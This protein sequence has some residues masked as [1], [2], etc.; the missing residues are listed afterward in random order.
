MG[1]T[2][3]LTKS[4]ARFEAPL[5]LTR[6]DFG[7]NN[8]G[9]N[10]PSWEISFAINFNPD[11]N[12][13]IGGA[14]QDAELWEIGIVQNLLFERMLYEYTDTPAF[15]AEFKRSRVDIVDNS[16]DRPFYSSPDVGSGRRKIRPVAHIWY[17]SQ[18]Y[19]EVLDPSNSSGVQTNN[20]PDSLN[21]WDQPS[22]GVLLRRDGSLLKRIEKVLSFQAWLVVRKKG[23]F[24]LS[25]GLAQ[26][27]A[28]RDSL[29]PALMRP[30]VESTVVL[31]QVPAF[32][33]TF[34]LTIIDPPALGKD[35]TFD[36]GVYGEDGFLPK[37]P[38]NHKFKSIL[39]PLPSA[40]PKLGGNVPVMIGPP[41]AEQARTWLSANSLT[42][43]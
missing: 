7:F 4:F 3:D 16:F 27:Q 36:Y 1:I 18:G 40:D 22:G 39:G 38:I 13:G 28:L 35:P 8:F 9:Y 43:A 37:K 26:V 34:W 6:N 33:L 23:P 20:Q 14:P 2:V 21:M 15:R 12:K 17:S 10:M 31:A 30:F 25:P 11:P 32:T 42:P 41:A 24:S 29:I 5:I 19:G